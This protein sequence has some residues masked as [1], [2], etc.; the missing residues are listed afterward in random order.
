MVGITRIAKIQNLGI[1]SNFTWPNEPQELDFQK[2]N[3]IYGYNGSGKTMLS[4]VI[5]LFS[6]D[7]DE[8]DQKR[9]AQNMA[10]DSGKDV[11]AEMQCDGK[12]IKYPQDRCKVFVFNSSF[13]ADHVYYGSN[14]KIRRFKNSVI[15]KEQLANLTVRKYSEEIKDETTRKDTIKIYRQELVTLAEEIKKSLSTTWNA[16]INGSRLPQGLNLNNC[17][18][19]PPKESEEDLNKALEDQFSKYKITKDQG[20]LEKDIAFLNQ[21]SGVDLKFP[22]ALN[23]TLQK[24]IA[25]SAR[26][27]VQDKIE[28]FKDHALKHTTAQNWFEDGS[29]LLKHNKDNGTCPLCDSALLN[30]DEIIA[31]YDAF[32]ND[33]LEALKM[34]IA[35]AIQDFDAAFLESEKRKNIISILITILARYGYQGLPSDSEDMAFQRLLSQSVK[36]NL[37]AV[38][39]L[40]EKK[41]DSIDYMPTHEDINLIDE[42][43]RACRQFEDDISSLLGFQNRILK[44]LNNARFND[45]NAKELCKKLFW[46]RFDKQG[47][48]KAN[49]W[50]KS[51]QAKG[52]NIKID[53]KE[54]MSG[55]SLYHFLNELVITVMQTISRKEEEKA[56]ELTKLKKESEYVNAFLERLCIRHFKITTENEGEITVLYEGVK[57]KKGIEYSLSE[58]EKTTLAFAYFLSKYQ[59]EVLDNENENPEDYIIVI[60]DPV[61][62]L[63]EN[64]LFSSA[65]VIKE[66]LVP[67]A[68]I[69][70]KDENKKVKW[71]GNKQI[72]IFSHNIVFLK[73]MG[74]VID[75]G[76]NE[77][78]AEFLLDKGKISFLPEVLRNYQTS[79]FYKLNKVKAF[80]DGDV[81]YET[82]KDY[83]PNY[84]RVV[85]EA[86]ISFKFARLRGNNKH[87]PAM[88][89][90]LIKHLNGHGHKF[91][92]F[93]AAG[94]I[95]CKDTLNSV[96]LQIKEKVNPEIHGTTQDITHLEYLPESELKET[97]IQTLNVIQYLDQ[98][99]YDKAMEL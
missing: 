14:E 38:K 77:G 32:F 9:I 66:F 73:F 88:L 42:M 67:K 91:V 95:S 53:I 98:I 87:I 25:E 59:Y 3:L 48:S 69:T 39:V 52:N 24:S 13:V 2:I 41:L 83:L 26:V 5:S 49:R 99:H 72:F 64:R 44:T 23:K 1:F 86:F 50:F 76:Q 11:F 7:L 70:G 45:R 81:E 54:N 89:D 21:I 40:Y 62:S 37:E 35:T 19:T 85:L 6:N 46:K 22:D 57:P 75:S 65:L 28:D 96:L 51:N 94:S 33:D 60:D 61:S 18:S 30:I 43:H 79:Y 20:Q 82:A 12:V 36:P 15:T 17:P 78:R 27:K 97:A 92:N 8:L 16:N 29:S 93:Q 58:G 84:I 56:S 10:S 55:I 31:S 74:N 47:K 71:A 90:S 34:E 80:I 68:K 63:D 4:N